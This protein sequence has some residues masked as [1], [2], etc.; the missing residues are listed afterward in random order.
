MWILIFKHVSF[1][2]HFLLQ[3]F[4][5]RFARIFIYLRIYFFEEL[6]INDLSDF[7]N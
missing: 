4:L 5:F 7:Q 6:S 1:D 2:V 3:Y